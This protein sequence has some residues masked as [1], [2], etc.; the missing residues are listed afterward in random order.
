LTI[1]ERILTALDW[2]EPDRVP[3][4]IYDWMLPRGTVERKL[5]ECGV[6][7][8]V[9]MPAHRL[10][11]Q[12]VEILTREYQEKG[13]M[14]VRRTIR[15]PVGEVWQTLEPDSAYGTSHWIKHHFIKEPQ[16]YRV[17]E[18]YLRDLTY[19]DNYEEIR[20]AQ[21]RM[22][23]DGIVLVRVA[24]APLQEMLYQM[25]GMERFS[26]DYHERR[27]LFDSLHSLLAERYGQLYRLAAGSPVEIVQLADNITADV[28]GR[29]RFRTYLMPEY[30]KLRAMLDQ[31]GK[32]LAVHMDGRLASLKQDIA[33][34]E[35]DILEA[36]TPPPMGDV[37]VKEARQCWPDKSLW[38]NFTSCMH[39]ASDEEIESHT[40]QLLQ[41]AGSKRGFA[42][43]VT[44]DAPVEALERSLAVISRVLQE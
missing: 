8:V 18:Y 13:R 9:R 14:L 7:L 4:T 36:M 44:E 3:L 2:E 16:D 23:E 35:F 27:D 15:T 40:R 17:M 37:S 22:G 20:A 26:Q 33:A 29:E 11:H 24:K 21:R 43:G 42:I 1:K 10:C 30:H 19:Q 34:A 5:R 12:E 28:V 38:I 25:M 6:G 32:K 39:I 31:A 41:E